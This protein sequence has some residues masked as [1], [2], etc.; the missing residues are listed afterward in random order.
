MLKRAEVAKE[1]C[2]AHGT[3]LMGTV[4]GDLHDIGTK[5]SSDDGRGAGL[6]VVDIG[7][8]SSLDKFMAAPT[9][10]TQTIHWDERAAHDHDDYRKTVIDGRGRG[11]DGDQVRDR[12]GAEQARFSPTRSAP[13]ATARTL[14][15]R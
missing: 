8:D 1:A 14:G 11:P 13:T 10:A 9:S 6:E 3:L 2:Q 4:R 5:P 12:R 7:V 15:R